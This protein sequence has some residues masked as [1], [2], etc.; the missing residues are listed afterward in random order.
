MGTLRSALL[1]SA[2]IPPD[3]G[4]TNT[5]LM[6]HGVY[7][8]GRNWTTLAREM[9][10][11]RRDWS[12]LL[13]D[14]RLHGDSPAFDPPHTVAAAARDVARLEDATGQHAAAVLGHSFG[15]KVA[16][17]HAAG[18]HD[19]LAQ[20][21]VVDSTPEV[22]PPGGSAWRMLDAVRALPTTF[23]SRADAAE[24][25]ARDGYSAGVAAWMASNLEYRDGRY[26]WRLDF[27]AIEALLHDFFSTDLWAIVE[28][29]PPDLTLHFVKADDS[30]VL[31]DDAIA[32]LEAAGRRH[33]RVSLH[34]LPGGHWLHVDNPRGLLELLT[35]YLLHA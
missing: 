32:R 19:R 16:L 17:A 15:G 26:A 11:I 23:A 30:T 6:L 10:R 34:H 7:G 18:G 29:P 31:S 35:G 22:K 27:D 21:W 33:G 1:A 25:L 5:L 3:S 2:R 24:G 12:T 13:I 9:T 14:L 8:R 4:A 28:D 20:V